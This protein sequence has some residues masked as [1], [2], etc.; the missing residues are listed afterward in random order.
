[1]LSL[2]NILERPLADIWE[3]TSRAFS[4]PGCACYANRVAA[5]IR[6]KTPACYPLN[7]QD[8]LEIIGACPPDGGEKRPWMYK[9]MG[10]PSSD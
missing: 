7:R 1:M 2:G 8:S 5:R 10:D 9:K 6:D 4:R 3:E